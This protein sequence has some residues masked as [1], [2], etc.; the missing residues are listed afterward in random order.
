VHGKH[1]VFHELG[2]HVMSQHSV[3][4][5]A[6]NVFDHQARDFVIIMTVEYSE[7]RITARR[8]LQYTERCNVLIYNKTHSKLGT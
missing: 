1:G 7:Q 8:K 6:S 3:M 5:N 2:W 4:K